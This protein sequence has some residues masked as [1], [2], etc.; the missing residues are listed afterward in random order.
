ML[1][2]E[3]EKSI[4]YPY[5]MKFF[6]L[7]FVFLFYPLK[8]VFSCPA[9]PRE[10]YTPYTNLI[11]RTDRIALGILE[12]TR[13][14]RDGRIEYLFK[15]VKVVKGEVGETFIL[16]DSDSG[17]AISN[18]NNL[19]YEGHANKEFWENPAVGRSQSFFDCDCQ[20]HPL[21]NQGDQYLIFLGQPF[22]LP[23]MVWRRSPQ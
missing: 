4:M 10:Q 17:L 13:L 6:L 12:K 11:Q 1:G 20:I 23:K 16:V 5:L 8:S 3:K 7:L 19:D 2:Y 18:E 22:H 21:F 14:L 9:I 15:T